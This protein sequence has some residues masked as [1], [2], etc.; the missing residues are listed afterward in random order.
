[1]SATSPSCSAD[2]R[3]AAVHA[4]LVTLGTDGDVYPYLG[5][6]MKL[7]SRGHRVTLAAPEQFESLAAAGDI[8]FHQLVSNEAMH[9]VLANPDFWHPLKSGRTA[10]SWGAGMIP[11]HYREI[12][13]LARDSDTVLIANPGIVAARLVQEKNARPLISLLLQPG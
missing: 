8:L 13:E 7:P 1:M 10:A 3:A 9:A 11:N 6:G 12:S 4:I 2:R 5:L